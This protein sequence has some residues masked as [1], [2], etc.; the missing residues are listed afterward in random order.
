M[1]PLP[2][3]DERDSLFERLPERL[4]ADCERVPL[5]PLPLPLPRDSFLL[6]L[7]ELDRLPLPL[8]ERD[9]LPLRDPC[10][11]FVDVAI[12]LSPDENAT[13]F[14]VELLICISK[15]MVP[16]ARHSHTL[17]SEKD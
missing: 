3:F 12:C 10:R 15:K 14:L 2:R 16:R 1:P 13:N 11:P 9:A 4:P 17:Q 8:F 7:P 6:P 5:L